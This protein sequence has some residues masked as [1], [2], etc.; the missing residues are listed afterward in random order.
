MNCSSQ[1]FIILY[2]SLSLIS[3]IQSFGDSALTPSASLYLYFYHILSCLDW[4][5]GLLTSISVSILCPTAI[6]SLCHYQRNLLKL[7]SYFII[8]LLKTLRWFHLLLER[9]SKSS[10][11][12]A[13]YNIIWLT[14]SLLLFS[15]LLSVFR[16][17]CF[18]NMWSSESMHLL[19]PLSW[20][21]FPILQVLTHMSA[22][23]SDFPTLY[24]K[25]A[26][27]HPQHWF[28][29]SSI[30]LI[31]TYLPKRAQLWCVILPAVSPAPGTHLAYNENALKEWN[32][33]HTLSLLQAAKR[34]P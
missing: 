19:F 34:S 15:P 4:S 16:S 24:L 17:F 13:S 1:K 9:N 22:P 32:W 3:Y 14:G 30:L 26:H 20:T 12:S 31:T 21:F 11:R 29:I 8:P 23:Q 10:P 18:S 25:L 2:F 27:P 28:S 5:S 6:H 33:S 7:K